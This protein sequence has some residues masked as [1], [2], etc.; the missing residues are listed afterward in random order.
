MPRLPYLPADVAEPA[1]LVAAIRARRRGEL[2]HIDRMLL[3]SPPLTR[4]WNVYLGAVRTELELDP[5]LRELAVCAVALLTGAEYEVHH[6]TSPFLAA[7]GTPAQLDAL[8]RSGGADD[9]TGAFD[10]RERAVLRLALEMTLNVVVADA[11][12]EAVRSLLGERG[13]VELVAL[14]A[15]YNMVA[16]FLVALGIEPEPPRE[17]P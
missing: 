11:T 5:R 16:R 9:G 15:T 13:V 7:G 4:G 14:V 12:F 10:E 1:D 2:L 8:R 6:H 3:R 17:A